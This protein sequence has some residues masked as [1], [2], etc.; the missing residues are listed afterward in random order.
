MTWLREARSSTEAESGPHGRRKGDV[1]QM[2]DDARRQEIDRI[3]RRA[4]AHGIDPQ[5]V[6][7]ALGRTEP[8]PA[9][10]QA[11]QEIR[12]RS[13][14]RRAFARRASAQQSPSDTTRAR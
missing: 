7:L 14:L 8:S 11:V 3:M 13:W 4:E 12:P 6:A 9:E 1:R 2:N 5:R 10:T